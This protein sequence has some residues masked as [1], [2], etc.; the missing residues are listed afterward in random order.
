MVVISV[1]WLY[2]YEVLRCVQPLFCI[3]IAGL[4]DTIYPV[5]CSQKPYLQLRL[6]KTPRCLW[7]TTLLCVWT[8][9]R[10]NYIL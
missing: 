9:F 5:C 2:V 8:C 10:L 4:P 3:G 1:L 6:V 7:R